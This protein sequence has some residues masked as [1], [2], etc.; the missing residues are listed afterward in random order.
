M[1]Y[2]GKL[3]AK[4]RNDRGWTQQQL[5]TA[6]TDRGFQFTR[7]YLGGVERGHVAASKALLVG[8][9]AAFG[10]SRGTLIKYAIHEQ[11]ERL[12]GQLG[13]TIDEYV[14][15]VE[16]GSKGDDDPPAGDGPS[17]SVVAPM[18]QGGA[19]DPVAGKR[20]IRRIPA[21]ASALRALFYYREMLLCH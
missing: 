4:L 2:V 13:L 19:R 17:E 21:V 18:D 10:L 7:G 12:A 15:L 1:P 20:L 5:S 14:A 8:C 3:I 16:Q 11:A 9:E 6:L